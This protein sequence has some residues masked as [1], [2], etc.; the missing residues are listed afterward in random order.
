MAKATQV[1]VAICPSLIKRPEISILAGDEPHT[2][3]AS[4]KGCLDDALAVASVALVDRVGGCAGSL[5][6]RHMIPSWLLTGR[7]SEV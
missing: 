1:T 4:G 5:E 7:H 3:V 2:L 6:T